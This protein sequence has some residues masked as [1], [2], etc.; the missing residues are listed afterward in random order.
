MAENEILPGNTYKGG[1]NGEFRTV[2]GFGSSESHV[3]WALTRERLPLGGF[4][5]TRVSTRASFAKWASE[6]V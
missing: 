4:A 5:R 3:V 2:T 1:K 6:K